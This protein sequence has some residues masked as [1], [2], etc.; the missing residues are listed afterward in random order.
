MKISMKLNIEPFEMIKNGKKNYEL[1]LFDAKRRTV[2]V[3]DAI[4]FVC[5][6]TGESLAVK[7]VEILHFSSFIDLY[8]ALSPLEIGYTEQNAEKASPDDMLKYYSKEEQDCYG[9]V[10]FK[11]ESV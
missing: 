8:K 6:S 5:S 11:I 2:K 10:A 7:V 3:G 1:R 4:Q 9:V